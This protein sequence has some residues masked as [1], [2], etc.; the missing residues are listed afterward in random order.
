MQL[1]DREILVFTVRLLPEVWAEFVPEPDLLRADRLPTRIARDE[2]ISCEG[3]ARLVLGTLLGRPPRAVLVERTEKGKPH[4]AGGPGFS[5]AHAGGIGLVA[6]AW[7]RRV[8]VDL[9]PAGRKLD[10]AA[11]LDWFFPERERARILGEPEDR[12]RRATLETFT[13]FEAAVK[14]TG[15]GL[16]VPIDDFEVVA[17]GLCVDHVDLGGEWIASVAADWP[18]VTARVVDAMSWV[19]GVNFR[20]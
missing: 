10:H 4:V 11:L 6:V 5:M 18:R 12:R 15:E 2:A 19:I 1:G 8:G 3:A 16:T 20:S 13:R 17:D 14:A 7:R 9:E